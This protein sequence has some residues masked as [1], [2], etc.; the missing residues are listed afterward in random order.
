M[1]EEYEIIVDSGSDLQLDCP[2]LALSRHMLFQDL[3]DEEFVQI[4]DGHVA[5][6][7][8]ALANIDPARCVSISAGAIMKAPIAA[9]F[10]WRKYDTLR[11]QANHPFRNVQSPP[12]PRMGNLSGQEGRY[13]QRK[14]PGAW[15]CGYHHQLY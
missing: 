4:A 9:I 15:R 8:K 14:N 3:S 11:A 12:R 13:S 1:R 5:A 2:D 6:L 10:P 7:N